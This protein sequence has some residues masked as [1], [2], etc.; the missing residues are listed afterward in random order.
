[1]KGDY[2]NTVV[3]GYCQDNVETM[4]DRYWYHSTKTGTKYPLFI[5]GSCGVKIFEQNE[6][7]WTFHNLGKQHSKAI[8]TPTEMKKEVEIDEVIYEQSKLNI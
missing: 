6:N 1:M 4:R 7:I 3:C 8:I 2:M 5:H